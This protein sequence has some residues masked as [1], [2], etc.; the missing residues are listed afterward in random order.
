MPKGALPNHPLLH[1]ALAGFET[2]SSRADFLRSFG[3]ARLPKSSAV[4]TRAGEMLLAQG[5]P[6]LALAAVDK[7]LLADPTDL[8]AQRLRFRVLNAMPR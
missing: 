8:P 1:I 6:E 4:C 5:C 7:A 3:L 2:D